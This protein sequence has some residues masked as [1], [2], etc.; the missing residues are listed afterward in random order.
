MSRSKIGFTPCF[1]TFCTRCCRP[2]SKC[3]YFLQPNCKWNVDSLYNV[4]PSAG[5]LLAS[6]FGEVG[7]NILALGEVV[8]DRN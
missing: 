6:F 8:G 4:K 3:P 7:L 5:V 2:D 1:K